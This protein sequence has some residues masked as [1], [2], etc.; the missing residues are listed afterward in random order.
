MSGRPLQFLDGV[1]IADNLIKPQAVLQC[2]KERFEMF[3][4]DLP[5]PYQLLKRFN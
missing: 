2:K 5:R 1:A 4:S 3:D